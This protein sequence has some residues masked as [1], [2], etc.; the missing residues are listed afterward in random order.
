MSF[1]KWSPWVSLAL[2]LIVPTSVSAADDL[3]WE[4]VTSVATWDA[5]PSTCSYLMEDGH[6][7]DGCAWEWIQVG[8]ATVT[9]A[10]SVEAMTAACAPIPTSTISCPTAV[11]LHG[12]ADLALIGAEM[13]LL[14]CIEGGGPPP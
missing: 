8:A 10:F 12:V 4:A 11:A 13:A 14:E 6:G 9:W 5:E 2:L 1:L 7:E 3:G